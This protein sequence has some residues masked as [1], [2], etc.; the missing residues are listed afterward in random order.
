MAVA[1]EKQELFDDYRVSVLQDE[2]VL[3]LAAQQ[4]KYT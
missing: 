4:C 3:R 1:G 2:K